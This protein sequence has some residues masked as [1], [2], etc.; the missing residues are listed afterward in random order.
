MNQQST[1]LPARFARVALAAGLIL[2]ATPFLSAQD[3]AAP[4]MPAE[5]APAA[6]DAA[7]PAEAG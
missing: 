5:T 1:R 7:A 3:A 4:E 6:N 2:S